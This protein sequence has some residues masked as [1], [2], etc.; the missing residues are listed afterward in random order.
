MIADVPVFTLLYALLADSFDAVVGVT[1]VFALF[2]WIWRAAIPHLFSPLLAGL[3]T[4]CVYVVHGSIPISSSPVFFFSLWL[5]FL[6]FQF[7]MPFLKEKISQPSPA[8]SWGQLAQTGLSIVIFGILSF[9][10]FTT[11]TLETRFLLMQTS[12]GFICLLLLIHLQPHRIFPP[13]VRRK[14]GRLCLLLALGFFLLRGTFWTYT[15]FNAAQSGPA[16]SYIPRGILFAQHWAE[17]WQFHELT[18]II[19]SHWYLRAR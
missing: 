8:S 17:A 7:G 1:L 4:Y 15:A 9:L 3:L 13:A 11:P 5:P 16:G 6:L 14:A 10:F 18:E 19:Q 12:V 2:F